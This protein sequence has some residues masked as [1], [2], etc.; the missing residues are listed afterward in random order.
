MCRILPVSGVIPLEMNTTASHVPGQSTSERPD[1]NLRRRKFPWFHF[2]ILTG[3]GVLGIFAVFPL[4]L[5][6]YSEK[7]AKISISLPLLIVLQTL[8]GGVLL[9]GGTALGLVL[10]RKVGLTTPLLD[11]L[12]NRRGALVVL[13][14]ILPL[15]LL[16]GSVAFVVVIFSLPIFKP[17]LPPPSHRVNIA[18][19]KGL[20]ASLYGGIDEEIFLRLFLMTLLAWLLSLK[21]RSKDGSLGKAVLLTANVIAAL[22]FGAGHLPVMAAVR[23]LTPA[24]VAMALSLNGA[25]GII[26]GSLY[27]SRGLEAA[28]IAHCFADILL[29]FV[30]PLVSGS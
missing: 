15:A 14:R 24:V 7:L 11:A 3:L 6:A 8:Q 26:L 22:V 19:W 29:H 25:G 12:E 17:Y 2:G 23:P 4:V 21:W 30:K 10:G 1:D 13:K 27:I 20:L 9:G 5:A 16:G 28:M 18:P